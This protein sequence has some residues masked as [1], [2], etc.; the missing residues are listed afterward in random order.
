MNILMARSKVLYIF[1]CKK[2]T[3]TSQLFNIN[4]KCSYA[5]LQGLRYPKEEE[6]TK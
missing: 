1:S 6:C 2:L 5:L 3:E 4:Q